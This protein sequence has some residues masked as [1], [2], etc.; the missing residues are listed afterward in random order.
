MTKKSSSAYASLGDSAYVKATKS[1]GEERFRNLM[2]AARNYGSA[3]ELADAE[4]SNE[5][6]ENARDAATQALKLKP[7]N[8]TAMRLGDKYAKALRRAR[9]ESRLEKAVTPVVI[10]GAFIFSLDLLA[11]K[12]TGNAVGSGNLPVDMGAGILLLIASVAAMVF[13]FKPKASKPMPHPEKK[14]RK[15]KAKKSRKK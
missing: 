6:Y 2:A 14:S 1:N 8:P 13:L 9:P 7:D 3:G 12:I 4:N 10:A 11:P 5:L 15:T